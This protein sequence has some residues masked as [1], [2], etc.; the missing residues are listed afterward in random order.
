MGIRSGVQRRRWPRSGVG[1]FVSE[2]HIK[3]NIENSS[4][5]GDT[6][7]N[8]NPAHG[9]RVLGRFQNSTREDVDDAVKA[10][11]GARQ[12]WKDTPAPKRGEILF[13]VAEALLK[14]K[15]SLARDM[16]R[17]MGKVAQETSGDVQ[18]AID[19]AY[20]T[21]GEGRRLLGETTPSELKNKFCMSVRMP[22]GVVAAI[23]PWN[24]PI[25][26]PSWKLIPALVAGNTVV[27]KPASDTPLSA[28]NFVKLFEKAGLPAG[29]LNLVTG[30]GP[31]VG[32]RHG[33]QI[34][35]RSTS[36]SGSV[37]VPPT[38]DR[39]T[40]TPVGGRRSCR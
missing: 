33:P 10:A 14:D 3:I 9:K 4:Q 20:Y 1:S 38:P 5:V 19:M 7:D 28:V 39:P 16:T 25:A 11:V 17:E 18:E 6:F 37:A 13:R 8:V 24:F 22:V 12:M 26:I 27:L 31:T 21:A 15:K 2:N 29:V 40:W 32:A 30:S 36:R 23:T 34:R 35:G